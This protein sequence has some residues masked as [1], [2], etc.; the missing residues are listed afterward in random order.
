MPRL[1]MTME[2]GRVVAW[3][4]GMGERVERGQVLLVIETEKAEAEIEATASGTLRAIYVEAGNTVACGTLLGALTDTPDEAF[5]AEEFRRANDR[6]IAKRSDA[7]ASATTSFPAARAEPALPPR[8]QAPV[9]P[10][11]RARARE[12]GVDV[13]QVQGTGPGGRVT[14]QDV[15]AF[16]EARRWRIDVGAVSLDVPRSGAGDPV[17]LLPGFGVDASAF[18]RQSEALTARASVFGVNPRGVGLSDAPA[19]EAYS[20]SQAAADAAALP[21]GPAHVVGASL[22]AAVALEL[23]LAYPERVRSLALV[24]PFVE[25][26]ARLL[27]VLEL[28][29]RV[30]AEASAEVLASALLPWLFSETLLADP[31]AR[32]RTARGLAGTLSR[33]GPA[34]LA[35]SASGLRAWSGTRAR[36][37]G[38]VAARTLVVVAGGDLL[39]PGGER[40]AGEIPGARCFRAEG[41]GHAVCLEAAEEVTRALELHLGLP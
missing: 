9:A 1:G 21:G 22:G 31:A 18:A 29:C 14:R 26:G 17:W 16:A 7:A 12:L 28:W 37:L 19:G 6:P 38:R 30:A 39:T 40:I 11:A 2:E 4:I 24:T 33:A 23:A 25:A 36:D 34:A 35:R 8:A 20:V 32:A 13:T 3:H 5:D 15:D 27:A 10:A 41:S